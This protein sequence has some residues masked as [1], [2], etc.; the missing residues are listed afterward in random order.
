MNCQ[1]Y[2]N[3]KYTIIDKM[4][5]DLDLLYFKY[6]IRYSKHL[7]HTINEGIRRAVNYSFESLLMN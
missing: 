1:N 2:N 3:S 6:I 5:K 7:H 4:N